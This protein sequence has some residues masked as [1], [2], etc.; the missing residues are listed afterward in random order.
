MKIAPNSEK[1]PNPSTHAKK[2]LPLSSQAANEVPS[3]MN[4]SRITM[5]MSANEKPGWL[6]QSPG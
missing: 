3:S 4:A 5:S 6:L 2:K 1:T